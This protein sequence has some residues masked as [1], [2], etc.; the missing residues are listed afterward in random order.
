[1]TDPTAS[2]LLALHTFLGYLEAL[3]ASGQRHVWMTEEARTALKEVCRMK[4]GKMTFAQRP[5]PVRAAAAPET[6]VAVLPET[7]MPGLPVA[8]R[9]IPDAPPVAA[10][11]PVPVPAAAPVVAKPAVVAP[12]EMPVPQPRLAVPAL[13]EEN[14]LREEPAAYGD[15][16]ARL[17]ALRA[18]AAAAPE[19][20]ALGSLRDIMVFA[21]GD[22][23]ARLML[24]GE[25]PGADEELQGEPFVGRAG[26][27]LNRIITAMGLE[28]PSIYISNICKYRPAIMDR[29]QGMSNRP[30]SVAEMDSCQRFIRE[31]IRIVQ[32][33]VIVALGNTAVSGLLGGTCR[34]LSER[35][36]WRS[37]EGIPVMPTLHPSYLLH[38]EQEADNGN[39]R[40]R[41]VWED[42]MAVM[43][44]LGMPVSPRQRRFFLKP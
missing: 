38:G 3:A 28:R 32:P 43:E 12:P 17:A 2:P 19:A 39:A 40:K 14:R 24:V 11:A 22:P 7:V 41:L 33:E 35:G 16:A 18:A 26:M 9:E 25:A 5:Q 23:D 4:P 29:Q 36:H 37:Y 20:R 30:P 13:A 44:R 1:M 27:L 21:C 34:I 31:E 10:P 15:K 42:M 6:A 8:T